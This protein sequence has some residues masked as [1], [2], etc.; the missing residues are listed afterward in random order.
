MENREAQSSAVISAADILSRT[1]FFAE[2]SPR[3]LYEI[4]R[5]CRVEEYPEG[6]QVY[7]LGEPARNF[8]ILA[9]GIVSFAV[10]FGARNASAGKILKH[11]EVFG[12]AAVTPG[13]QR[14]IATASCL[15]PCTVLAIDGNGLLELMESDHALGYRIMK[16]VNVLITG[17]LTAFAA[18]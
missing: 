3:Q 14:R 2:L 13:A 12:W 16:Q 11:G 15:T 5:L 9:E 6:A 4:S 8:Y 17:T 1:G 7:R 18:G 10:G